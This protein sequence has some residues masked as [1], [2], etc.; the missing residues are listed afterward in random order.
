MVAARFELFVALIVATLGCVQLASSAAS[1]A[2]VPRAREAGEHLAKRVV[3]CNSHHQPR[4]CITVPPAARR[5]P[6]VNQQGGAT[7]TPPDVTDGG[8]LGGGP[9]EGRATALAWAKTQLGSSIWAWR[10]ERFVEESYGTRYQFATAWSAANQLG[11]HAQPITQAPAGSLVF[12]GPD[13]ANHGYGHVGLSLGNGE[14][15]SALATV[16]MTDVRTSP[17]WSSLYRGWAD[18]PAGWPGRIPPPPGP[19]TPLVSSAIEITAPAFDSTVSGV[20]QLEASAQNVGGV[21]FAAY[22]ATDPKNFATVGWHVLGDGTPQGSSWGFQWDTAG[23]PDQGFGPWGTVNV[24]A[25]AL[26]GSGAET[27]TRDYRRISVDNSGGLPPSTDTTTT[28][29][30]TASGGSPSTGG[31]PLTGSSPVTT[32]TTSAQAAAPTYPETPGSVVHTWTNYSDAG[33]TEGP[34]IPSNQT[35][36]IACKVAGFAVADGD[37][38]WYRI[39]SSPWNDAYYGSADAFY[40]NGQTS[41]SLE[42]TPFVDQNV[43]D[44]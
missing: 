21:A 31:P 7:L 22:Y 30:N 19:T 44:C 10:C 20:V 4:G 12:F 6:K 39:A 18:A 13:G 27:G 23:I 29:S 40:N 8:G 42:G 34:T 15:I 3:D 43:P 24:A 16:R 33:G 14:M 36:Q 9:G 25:I 5:P 17:Y 28:T 37:T 1:G 26:N 38:W 32:T 11:L 41:G 35:V 2:S